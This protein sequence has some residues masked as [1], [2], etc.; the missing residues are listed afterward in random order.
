MKKCFFLHAVSCAG[1]ETIWSSLDK[2]MI[3]QMLANILLERELRRH[4][5]TASAL[6]TRYQCLIIIMVMSVSCIML[7]YWSECT[8]LMF[9]R[10]LCWSWLLTAC[11]SP[12]W[13]SHDSE[14][15][16]NLHTCMLSGFSSYST[17]H[18]LES[19]GR[20]CHFLFSCLGCL[21][22]DFYLLVWRCFH[23]FTRFAWKKKK[24]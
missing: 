7:L 22:A 12:Q 19:K 1:W 21:D 4:R 13:S 5:N 3:A 15:T 20:L 2:M 17:N 23:R 9:L 11:I 16:H 18:R 10:W 14:Y 8:C 6:Q 24:L